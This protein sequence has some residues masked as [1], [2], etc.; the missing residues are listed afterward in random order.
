M[1]LTPLDCRMEKILANRL[2]AALMN[3]DP[4]TGMRNITASLR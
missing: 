3:S 1:M 4:N 2:I